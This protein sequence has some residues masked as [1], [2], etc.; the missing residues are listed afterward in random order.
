MKRLFSFILVLLSLWTFAQV[1]EA[2]KYQTIVRADNG[3]V[4]PFQP[5]DFKI[6]ILAGSATGTTV[7]R[8][9]HYVTS[10]GN[11][12][13]TFKIGLG[14]VTLGEFSSIDWGEASHYIK[15]EARENGTP[16]FHLMGI[17]EFAS[18]PYAMFAKNT[19]ASDVMWQQDGNNIYYMN[20]NVGIKTD[21]PTEALTIGTNNRIQLSTVKN[22]L[23]YG[24]VMKLRWT[25]ADAKPGIHWQ[26][27]NGLTKVAL[28]AYDYDTYPSIQS[29]KFSIATTN[30]AGDLIERFNV[31]YGANEVDVSI[32]NSN[33]KLVDGN[34]FQLGTE[35][36]SGLAKYYGNVYIHGTKK[37]GI[38]DKDWEAQGTWENAQMEIYRA[39]SD[40]VLLIHDDAGTN[41]V[42]LHLRNGENDWKMLHNGDFNINHEGQTFFKITS[43]GD[44]GIDVDE[45]IAKLDVNGNINVSSGFGYLVGGSGKGAYLPVNGELIAGDIA[46]MNPVSGDI[47]KYENGDI[48][49]GVVSN[50]AGFIENYSKDREK[51]ASYAL[52]VSKGQL[53]ANMSQLDVQDR[54]VYTKDG[55]Q[56]G[57][58]LNNGKVYIK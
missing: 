32:T 52:I 19:A 58:L 1:P 7:F 45:P 46:G 4:M 42:G 25:A 23:V 18:V 29:Q 6:S 9:E 47:R 8:E 39:N 16:S 55:Q 53:E 43:D 36:N 13:V 26:D 54:L 31:P 41:D 5:M 56:I 49:I 20:G 21:N 33:L 50:Q 11:G 38:G 2:I 37:M 30:Q 51:D 34:T 35:D 24:A 12:L 22:S 15:V 48:F 17:E 3:I 57:V 40:V 44:V 10:N 14:T 28:S 27:N